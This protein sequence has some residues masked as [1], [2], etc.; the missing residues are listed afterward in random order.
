MPREL[1]EPILVSDAADDPDPTATDPRAATPMTTDVGRGLLWAAYLGASWTWVIGMFLPVLLIRDHGP[2]AWFIFAIPNVVGAAAMGW[3]I[4][5]RDHSLRF[6]VNHRTATRLFGLVTIAFHLFFLLWMVPRL[7][8]DVAASLAF[9]AALLVMLPLFV[10]TLQHTLLAIVTLGVSLLIATL[11][12]GSGVLGWP[13][14]GV[15]S[16]GLAAFDLI[17][18]AAVCALGF[19][20]CPYLDLTFHRARQECHTAGE[21]KIAFGVGFG[22]AFHSMIIV[23]LLYAGAMLGLMYGGQD[24]LVGALLGIHICVQAIFTVGIH[25]SALRATVATPHSHARMT[26]WMWLTI[27]GAAVAAL[28]SRYFDSRGATIGGLWFGEVCYRGF[29]SYYGLLAPAYV[30]LCV[31]PGR[32]FLP[33]HAKERR[34]MWLAIAI[35]APFY[36][37]GFIHGPMQWVLLGVGVVMAARFFLDGGRRDH[38][39]EQRSAM[40]PQTRG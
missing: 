23:T 11:L 15:P 37:L 20:T 14:V 17:G 18:L 1:G 39:A 4:R 38:L 22:V 12:G 32:G 6:V 7:I 2:I 3:T 16:R 13:D 35:A 9:G 24:R 26:T 19:I 25:A 29:M 33:S 40:L 36:W 31:H 34:M 30:W 10:T 21:S 8:G 28:G 5:S 27:A